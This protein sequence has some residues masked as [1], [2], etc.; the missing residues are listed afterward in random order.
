FL[1]LRRSLETKF[2]N[3]ETAGRKPP[4]SPV[5]ARK[6]VHQFGNLAPLL[7]VAAGRDRVL[8]AM[9]DVIAQ[10]LLLDPAQ[11]GA[12][13]GDLRDDVDA[14]AILFDH[15]GEPADLAFDSLEPLQA[16]RLDLGAHGRYIP[17]KGI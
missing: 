13:R 16:R 10:H 15:A 2:I 17:P 4:M 9:R 1:P 3:A 11:R 6:H 8:D 5:R 14:I 7:G 12:D